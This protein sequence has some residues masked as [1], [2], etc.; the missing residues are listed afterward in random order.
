MKGKLMATNS[1]LESTVSGMLATA[2]E[3]DKYNK[4]VANAYRDCAKRVSRL[5]Q[6]APAPP[7]P[8]P[9]PAPEGVFG[10]GEA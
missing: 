5:I 3:Q 4:D 7:P 1:E 9:P 2:E 8:P 10:V 6:A